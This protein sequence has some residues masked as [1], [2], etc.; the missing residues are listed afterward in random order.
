MSVRSI[1]FL[2][3]VVLGLALVP[4]GSRLMEL[5]GRL[6]LPRDEYFLIQSLDQGSLLFGL[7]LVLGLAGTTMLT[8]HLRHR[9]LG[10]G[11]GLFSVAHMAAALL[12]FL[13]WIVPANH[14]TDAWTSVPTDWESLRL[15]WEYAHIATAILTFGAF[16]A[17]ALLPMLVPM[18]DR[19]ADGAPAAAGRWRDAAT[20]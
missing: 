2:T 18:A 20:R 5:P 14:V 4:S 7:A 6:D 9:R 8:W 16:C 15:S 10:L 3:I 19:Q 12:V 13:I 11:L 17:T 1:S